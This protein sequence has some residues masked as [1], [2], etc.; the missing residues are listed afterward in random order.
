MFAVTSQTQTSWKSTVIFFDRVSNVAGYDNGT[1]IVPLV[2]DNMTRPMTLTGAQQAQ[3]RTNVGAA[4]SS[5][6]TNHLSNPDPHPVYTTQIENDLRYYTQ[7]QS[8]SLLNSKQNQLNCG[9][10]IKTINSE[11][12]LGSGDIPISTGA[13]G[14]QGPT[15]PPGPKGDTGDTGPQGPIGLTGSQG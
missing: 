5:D 1:S 12:L 9:A 14:P 11:C 8:N 2:Q 13:T 3:F 4:G 10:N 7:L 15:G 6:L